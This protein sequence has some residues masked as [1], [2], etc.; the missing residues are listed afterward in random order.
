ME[1]SLLILWTLASVLGLAA[2]LRGRDRFV[3][4]LRAAYD[5]IKMM[6]VRLPIALLFAGFL[7]ALI[8]NHVIAGWI[9][10]DS[11]IGGMFVASAAG[12]L[13]PS[14]PFVS[15]PIALTLFQS[16]AGLAQVIAF[17]T[18]WSAY[19][20]HRV[21]VWEVPLVGL[22]FTVIRLASS[23]VIPPAVGV[24]AMALLALF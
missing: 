6:I 13:V 11:G 5:L 8:P 4:G 14:G 23:L 19:A 24:L 2:L 16:G 12:G 10:A 3:A 15:F 1:Q 21:I 17:V 20:F 7:S 18:A 22:R 9:G